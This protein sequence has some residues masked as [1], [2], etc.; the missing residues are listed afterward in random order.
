VDGRVEIGFSG[1][2]ADDVA[3][4]GLQLGGAG[5][6]GQGRGFLDGENAV[7]ERHGKSLGQGVIYGQTGEF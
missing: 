1:A 3:A 4:L 2:E 6:H 5:R 7:G